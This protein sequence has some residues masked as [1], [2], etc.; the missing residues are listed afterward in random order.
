[1]FAILSI[2]DCHHHLLVQIPIQTQLLTQIM[3][4]NVTNKHCLQRCV[5]LESR[6]TLTVRH[7]AQ[8]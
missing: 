2:L 3:L 5:R 8:Q 1:M 4:R 6:H 7:D